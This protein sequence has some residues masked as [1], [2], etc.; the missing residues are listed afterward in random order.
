MKTTKSAL[1]E[2]LSTEIRAIVRE[3]IQREFAKLKINASPR[4]TQKT[5]LKKHSVMDSLT[6]DDPISEPMAPKATPLKE[7]Y[8][9]SRPEDFNALLE[10]TEVPANYY[11]NAQVTAPSST[12]T[13]QAGEVNQNYRATP[14]Q[15][16]EEVDG[17]DLNDL[18]NTNFG[19]FL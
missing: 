5:Q 14:I 17:E 19:A 1:R 7:K 8:D 16:A 10:T 12:P 15:A 11:Q 13:S 6:M 18:E 9:L 3:E 4:E 2:V